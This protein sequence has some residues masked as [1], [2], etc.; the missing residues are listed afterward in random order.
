MKK[1]DKVKVVENGYYKG[2]DMG[3]TETATHTV[4]LKKGNR[5]YHASSEKLTSFREKETC[6]HTEDVISSGYLY[7]A[8]VKQDM[9]V[10]GYSN[11]TE[12]RLEITPEVVDMYYA[13]QRITERDETLPKVEKKDRCGRPYYCYQ[14]KTIDKTITI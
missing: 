6:F 2:Q 1:G 3:W 9:T 5:L 12:V 13:G 11:D 10:Q 14:Y 4:S 7:V 8:I